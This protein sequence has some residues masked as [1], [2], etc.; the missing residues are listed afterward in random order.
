MIKLRHE[1]PIVVDGDFSLV[2]NT[3]D[4]VLAYYRILNDKKWLV[5]ANLSNEEQNFVSND[6]IET[7]LSNYPERNNVQNITL[8]PYEAFISKV[9][10]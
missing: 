9:I 1:N 10:E 4:A 3:Q 2:S 5:V 8:K 6:Q 7:I